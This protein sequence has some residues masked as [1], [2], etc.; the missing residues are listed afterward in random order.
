M[1][2]IAIIN[3]IV[4][5]VGVIGGLLFAGASI[6]SIANMTVPW[7][8]A[9]LVASFLVPVAFIVSGVGVWLIDSMPILVGL[10]IL[11]WAYGLLFVICML[12]SFKQ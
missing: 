7:R 1:R 11:P 2:L 5:I 8:G 3:S 4:C 9:L 10:V 6:I 12:V